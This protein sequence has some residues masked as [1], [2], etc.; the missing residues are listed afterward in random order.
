MRVRML[1]TVYVS[2]MIYK[3]CAV[4][5]HPFLLNRKGMFLV[6][7]AR[8]QFV[9]IFRSVNQVMYTQLNLLTVDQL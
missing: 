3:F 9:L 2:S 4:K 6:K 8:Q 7:L 5:R 1:L